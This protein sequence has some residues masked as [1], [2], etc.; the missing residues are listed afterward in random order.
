MSLSVG[1][2]FLSIFMPNMPSVSVFRM[3]TCCSRS[4]C[5]KSASPPAGR[6]C[7]KNFCAGL[8]SAVWFV[9]LRLK[10]NV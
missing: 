2:A 6:P 9:N 1:I 8:C 7:L 3:S 4:L 10:L 5:T